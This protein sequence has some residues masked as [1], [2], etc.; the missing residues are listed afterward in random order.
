M[1]FACGRRWLRCSLAAWGLGW[2][3]S[4][5][6]AADRALPGYS[7]RMSMRSEFEKTG[8]SDWVYDLHINETSAK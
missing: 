8:D 5:E 4:A 1:G 2:L 3:Q 6:V 7:L